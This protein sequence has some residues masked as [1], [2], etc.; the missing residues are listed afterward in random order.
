MRPEFERGKGTGQWHGG[1]IAAIID[2]VGDYALIM[3][4]RRG[5][6]TINFRVDYLRPAIKTAL[7][8]TATVRR[9]GKSVGVVDVDVFNEQKVLLADRPRDLFDAAVELSGSH[10]CSA[11]LLRN[12]EPDDTARRLMVNVTRRVFGAGALATGLAA[13]IRPSFA[14]GEP[15][16]GGTLVA[17]WGGGEPQACYVPSG[18]GSSPTFSSSKLFERLG[19]RTMSRRVR[20][21]AGGELEA[22]RGL[23]VLHRQAAPGREVPRRQADDRRRRGLFDRRDL[24]EVRRRL[25]DDRLHRH[26]GARRQHGRHEVRQADAGVLLRLAA[27]RQRQLHRAQARL[28]RQRSDHQP[29]NNAPI[30]HRSVEVQGVGARQPLRVRQERGLLAPGLPLHG[31]PDHPLRARSGRARRGDGSRARSRS[32]CSIRWRRPT[33]SG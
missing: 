1:P 31:S 29:A 24:E 19:N 12:E 7:I 4:L 26:R 2:T 21:R 23:Q 9:N 5:L 20:G 17:T 10:T 33:S 8:T 28:C 3:A 6:P 18:G 16:R 11:R 15:R 14:Q 25:G 32:A 30:A 13:G 22:R 27:L